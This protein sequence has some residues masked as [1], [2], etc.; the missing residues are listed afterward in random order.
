MFEIESKELTSGQKKVFTD[1]EGPPVSKPMR[2]VLGIGGVWIF[3]YATSGVPESVQYFATLFAILGIIAVLM[4]IFIQLLMNISYVRS[5][6]KQGCFPAGVTVKEGGMVVRNMIARGKA[7]ASDVVSV[8]A[9]QFYTFAEIGKIND[10]SEYFKINLPRREGPG[11][12][13][14]K[15]DFREGDPE[16]FMAFIES[17][18]EALE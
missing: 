9:E 12:C 16:A 7:E 17:K 11:I 14:F 8:N 4:A 5:L 1:K 10:L 3:Y 18:K 2:A 15:E 13:L 6:K